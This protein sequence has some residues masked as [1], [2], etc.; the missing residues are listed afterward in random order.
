[1]RHPGEVGW[2]GKSQSIT[3][4]PQAL[5]NGPGSGSPNAARIDSN[6]ATLSSPNRRTLAA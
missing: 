6:V 3:R 5:M 2:I 1:V 4:C